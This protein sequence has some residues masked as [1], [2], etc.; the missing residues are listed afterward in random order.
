M[1][2]K[3]STLMT[4]LL[5]LT[6]MA[7]VSA[8]EISL[9]DEPKPD[10]KVIGKVDITSGVVPIFTSKEGDWMKVGDPR[11][12]NVGWLKSSEMATPGEPTSITFT[13]K[14]VQDKNGPRNIQL[15]QYGNPQKLSPEQVADFQKKM[16][17][18]QK[19][20]QE[21]SQKAFEEMTNQMN[22]LYQWGKDNGLDRVPMIMPIVVVQPADKAQPVAKPITKPD[23]KA[24]AKPTDK[25]VMQP[26]KSVVQP[27]VKPMVK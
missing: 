18:Q 5:S 22:K 9:Y 10:A 7:N 24:V 8:K 25:A 11:N 4:A 12:G 6:V 1:K 3:L 23:E 15:L 21:Y 27:S 26:E 19:M 16:F 13:Q 20:I 14:I 17:E 2:I